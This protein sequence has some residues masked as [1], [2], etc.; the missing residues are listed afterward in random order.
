V[1]RRR[2][3][4]ATIPLKRTRSDSSHN[5]LGDYRLL[6][7]LAR[8]GTAA[9]YLA[10]HRGT[11]ER[12]AVKVLDPFHAGHLDLVERMIA[13]RTVS[14]HV[15]HPGLLDIRRADRSSAVRWR[16]ARSALP[17]APH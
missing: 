12:V 4:Q 17:G 5:H 6:A 9:V 14:E 11:A 2:S 7:P 16:P 13:E 10:E 3:T 15:R 1:S 8:G